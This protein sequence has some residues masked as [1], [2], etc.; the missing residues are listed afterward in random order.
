MRCGRQ[1]CRWCNHPQRCAVR[2]TLLFAGWQACFAR[3]CA[4]TGELGAPG[5][6]AAAVATLSLLSLLCCLTLPLALVALLSRG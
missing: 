6:A 4:V 3:R 1:A 2:D 5:A